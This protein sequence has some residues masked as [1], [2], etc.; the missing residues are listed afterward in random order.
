MSV[1]KLTIAEDPVE[2]KTEGYQ[3]RMSMLYGFSI[4]FAVTLVSG[5]WYYFV[6][7]DINWNASQTV[8][9]LHLAGGIMTLFLFVV[10][11]FLHMKDQEQKWWWLLTP[12]KLRRETDE[13]NQRFRQRQLGYFLTWAFLAIFVTGIVIA[14]PGLMFYTGKVWMQGYYTS[15]TL[16]GIHF[17]ASV[18]L[19]PVIFVHM[20]WLVR[21][22]GQ[23][24]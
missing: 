8:L 13:E 22:G 6:P 15:Q 18:I 9:V 7:R 24:S 12:W 20:L 10:F 17:W 16:L 21:K 23:R 1:F 19:V 5:F 3:N 11:F 2:K 4:A 14:V